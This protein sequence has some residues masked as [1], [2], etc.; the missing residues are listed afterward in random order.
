MIFYDQNEIKFEIYRKVSGKLP[1]I[2]KLNKTT[3]E[4]KKT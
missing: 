4:T 1:N 2:W 3:H